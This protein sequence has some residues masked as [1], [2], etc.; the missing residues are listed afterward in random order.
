MRELNLP[1]RAE[2][3]ENDWYLK[4]GAFPWLILDKWGV[5]IAR[6]DF[7]EQAYACVASVNIQ[8]GELRCR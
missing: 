8:K 7:E 6:F 5:V 4:N 1:W 2:K 3:A